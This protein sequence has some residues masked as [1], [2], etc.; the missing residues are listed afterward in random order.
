MAF[1]YIQDGQQLPSQAW[2]HSHCPSPLFGYWQSLCSCVFCR[3]QTFSETETRGKRCIIIKITHVSP[4]QCREIVP[5]LDRV[6]CPTVV[7]WARIHLQE[8]P[9]RINSETVH[10]RSSLTWIH[11]IAGNN[12]LRHFHHQELCQLKAYVLCSS[13]KECIVLPVL[14][15]GSS[16]SLEF[17]NTFTVWDSVHSSVG[18]VE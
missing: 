9:K 18:T 11:W 6:M 12:I 3:T 2:H 16:T 15:S 17:L 13:K 10:V 14:R 1:V 7:M 5:V 8:P 4:L